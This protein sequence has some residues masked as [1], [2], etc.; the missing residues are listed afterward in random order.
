MPKREK[1][2]CNICKGG[3]NQDKIVNE[4]LTEHLNRQPD[5][6][7]KFKGGAKHFACQETDV[8]LFWGE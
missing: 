1:Y 2:F 5:I 4:I 7:R 6:V 8:W 3:K